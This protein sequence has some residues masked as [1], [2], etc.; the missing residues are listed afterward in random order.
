MG[1]YHNVTEVV[2]EKGQLRLEVDG[3]RLSFPLAELSDRLAASTPEQ[4][5]VCEIIIMLGKSIMVK[6]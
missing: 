4:Q 1:N 6:E 2:V 3:K 5:H